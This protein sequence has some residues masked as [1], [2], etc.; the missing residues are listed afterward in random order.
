MIELIQ[1]Y[2]LYFLVGQYPNGPLGGLTL[3]IL[4]SAAALL[5]AMPLGLLLGVARVSP[6]RAVRWPVAVL[7]QVVRAVPLLLVVFWAYFF[8]PAVTGVKTGQATTMLMTLVLFDA[9]Y[10]AEIVK[11]GIQSL[12][13]GQLEGAR[14]LGL[15]YGQALRLV[16]LPQALRH[17]SPSLVSQL[18]ATIKATSL[19]YIIGLSEVSFIATQVNTLVFTK[20]VEVYII[21]AATY[22]ILCFGLSRLAFLLERRLNRRPNAAHAPVSVPKVSL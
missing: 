10:L 8:L 9:V 12:P 14:S 22:F 15:S 2:W 13:K 20:A 3:T 4:L 16:I 7:V 6:F 19:G 11:A 1:D 21:L 5:L 18:V 17:V